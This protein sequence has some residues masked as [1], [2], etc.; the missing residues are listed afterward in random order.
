V[1]SVAS[2]APR[3]DDGVRNAARA[4]PQLDD[5]PAWW[6]QPQPWRRHV[7]AVFVPAYLLAMF[8]APMACLL[9]ASR[10]DA[11]GAC[12]WAVIAP[13]AFL[14]VAC[15]LSLPHQRFVVAGRMPVDLAV[16][17]YFHR[18]LYGLCWTAVFYSGPIYLAVLAVPWLKRGVFSGFGYRGA[19]DFTAYPDTWI[20]DLPLLQL[21]MGCYLANKATIGTN[22]IFF[23]QGRKW[24]EVGPVTIGRAAMI[25]HMALVGPGCRIGDGATIGVVA[26]VGRRSVIGAAAIVGD[27]ASVDHGGELAVGAVVRAR[28]YVA[29]GRHVGADESMAYAE[30]LLRGGDRA[31]GAHAPASAPR[32]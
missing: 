3:A 27:G 16:P 13:L 19:L 21:G 10:C 18:R 8:A 15:V 20:R 5:Q 12:L 22:M 11:L 24:I 32:G 1:R 6:R 29:R 23:R 2:I 30:T 17:A 31:L 25:G 28:C 14:A 4:V 7:A 9:Q 26:A